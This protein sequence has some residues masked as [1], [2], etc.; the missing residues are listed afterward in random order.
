MTMRP[1]YLFLD[2]EFFF[3]GED[4]ENKKTQF[5]QACRSIIRLDRNQLGNKSSVTHES[6]L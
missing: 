5:V 3:Y 2:S 4:V 6:Y 1:V